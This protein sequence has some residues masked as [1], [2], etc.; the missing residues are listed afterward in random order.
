MYTKYKGPLLIAMTAAL[1]STAGVLIKLVPW[2]AMTIVG[3]RSFFAAV[4]MAVYMRRP[5]ITFSKPVILGG[6]S[7]S[8]TMVMFLFANKLT[9]AA[10]AIVLQY[11]API[12]VILMSALVLRQRPRALDIAA[13]AVV[14]AGVMLFF[15]DQLRADA[16]LGNIL[17]MLSGV[18]FA[19]VFLANRMPGARPEEASLLG[20]LINIVVSIPFIIT[21]VTAEVMP[22]LVI[23]VM[24]VFQMGI[25]YVLFSIGI[26]TTPPLA[27]SLIAVIE[28]LLSPV[29]VMMATGEKPGPYAIVGGVV[30]LGAVVAYNAITSRRDRQAAAKLSGLGAEK[31]ASNV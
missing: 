6:L 3:L 21:G 23:I 1:W 13:V 19:G 9:T 14:F 30:V 22:W 8:A 17:A 12:F 16:L 29:W 31:S 4:V 18:T 10:N 2:N 15:I 28:P 11:T 26:K 27:A 7:L 5:R 20:Y 24:G 25:A